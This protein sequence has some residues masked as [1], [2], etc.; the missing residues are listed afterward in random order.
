MRAILQGGSNSDKGFGWI[1]FGLDRWAKT[2]NG[3]S[4]IAV[5]AYSYDAYLV[6]GY[7]DSNFT[8][9][10]EVLYYDSKTGVIT[11]DPS[12]P[13][14]GICTISGMTITTPSFKNGALIRFKKG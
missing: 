13:N 4:T 7:Y 6:F 5:S 11:S 9:Y 14:P 1:P 12:S 8:Y 10:Y 2:S 3:F